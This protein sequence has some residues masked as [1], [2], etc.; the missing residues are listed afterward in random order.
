MLIY[1]LV[2]SPLGDLWTMY[3]KYLLKTVYILLARLSASIQDEERLQEVGLR[4]W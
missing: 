2:L 3:N 1:L 4:Q